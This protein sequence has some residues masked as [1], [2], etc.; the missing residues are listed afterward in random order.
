MPE[1]LHL[2]TYLLASCGLTIL[3]VWPENGP[4]AWLR[5]EVGRRLLPGKAGEVFDCYVCCGF[6][7][8]FILSPLWWTWYHE[9]WYWFGCLMVPAI[10]WFILRPFE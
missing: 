8:G 5:D 6:W 7:S 2:L 9:P 10:F 3:I 1:F 4:S